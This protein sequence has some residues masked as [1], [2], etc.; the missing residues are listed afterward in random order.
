MS[1]ELN[2]TKNLDEVNVEYLKKFDYQDLSTVFKELG[3]PSAWKAGK[4]KVDLIK[5][6][7]SQL[8]FLKKALKKND[9]E[10]E[11]EKK[12]V[13]KVEVKKT[14]VK[15]EG[16]KEVVKD[17]DAK[18]ALLKRMANI[19]AN[20]KNNVPAHR[21]ILLGKKRAIEAELALLD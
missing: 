21:L 8:S 10:S 3:V 2:V 17:N 11:V 9:E 15:K 1:K 4:K 19:D 16:K 20:L 7:I 14:E 18:E 5:E 6:A 13:E 12:D